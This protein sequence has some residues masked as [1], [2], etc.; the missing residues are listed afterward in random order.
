VIVGWK[1]TR[2][3]GLKQRETIEASGGGPRKSDRSDV[4]P[5]PTYANANLRL[6]PGDALL[7][8]LWFQTVTTFIIPAI[9]MPG[10][11]L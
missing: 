4:S 6:P 2:C 3:G 11:D 8:I 10:R 7:A 5:Q 9:V 1:G